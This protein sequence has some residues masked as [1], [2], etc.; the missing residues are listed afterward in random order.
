MWV[1]LSHFTDN[2]KYGDVKIFSLQEV[3]PN[4]PPSKC[5]LDL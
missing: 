4:S 3:E 1:I 5:G 2:K